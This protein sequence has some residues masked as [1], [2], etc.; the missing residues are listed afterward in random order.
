M[1]TTEIKIGSCYMHKGHGQCIVT[2]KT[3]AG[4]WITVWGG[5][6]KDKP[7][8]FKRIKA[9]DLESILVACSECLEEFE[10]HEMNNGVC[11]SCDMSEECEACDGTGMSGEW[12]EDDGEEYCIECGGKGM[13]P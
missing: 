10:S 1:T 3:K 6:S 12:D 8:T 11:E 7:Y 5:P 9:D 13:V 4:Y 2:H